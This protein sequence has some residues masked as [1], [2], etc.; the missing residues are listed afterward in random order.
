MKR[1]IFIFL[2]IWVLVGCDK[3]TLTTIESTIVEST[4]STIPTTIIT[5]TLLPVDLSTPMNF[6]IIN[7][8]MLTWD[9]C[10][11]AKKYI[12]TANDT[13]YEVTFN[14]FN[15]NQLQDNTLY[16]IKVRAVNDESQSVDTE[17]IEYSNFESSVV[18][19]SVLYSINLNHDFTVDIDH[20]SSIYDIKYSLEEEMINRENWDFNNGILTIKKNYLESINNLTPSLLL[21]TSSGII[22]LNVVFTDINEPYPIKGQTYIQNANQDVTIRFE[23]MDGILLS[24]TGNGITEEDYSFEA[25]ILTISSSFLDPL[26]TDNPARN[27]MIGLN[28]LVGEDSVIG[29]I[30]I[31]R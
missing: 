3:T 21:Y 19:L 23:M 6:Q 25:S 11:G 30:V 20:L 15:L 29:I 7:N 4:T 24:L 26:F 12:V 1:I 13:E 14:F 27:I 8:K 5:S 18:T 22:E 16:S 31:H 17:A 2:L 9:A 28:Y 10:P